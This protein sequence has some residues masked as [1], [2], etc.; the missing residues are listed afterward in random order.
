MDAAEAISVIAEEGF[1]V[2]PDL[3]E[4]QEAERLDA[5][6][7][8]LMDPEAGY[9]KLEGALNQIPDLAP[10]C[11]NPLLLE[12]VEHFLGADY[13]LSNNVA[14]MWCQ[15][16]GGGGHLH[17]DWPL[18]RVPQPW[19]RWTLGI[20]TMWMLTDF[21][22]ENGATRVVPGSHLSGG[23]PVSGREYS[24]EMPAVG[25]KGS[26][27]IWQTAL[28]HRSGKNTT[29]D[30]YRMGANIGFKSWFVHR[31]QK[32]WP[33]LRRKL[34]QR[35]PAELQKLLRRSVESA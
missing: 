28:W 34:Y 29:T 35:L 19:P 27:L 26:L 10:L 22:E 3:L 2:L 33:L 24:H 23:P 7:R 30:Q 8:P 14:K 6:A 32:E 11:M 15:P 4:S 13:F 16:G 31:P 18:F 1:C 12:I 5:L 20:Q 21:T 9:V 25:K 17:A